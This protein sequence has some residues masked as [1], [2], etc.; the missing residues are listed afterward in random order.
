MVGKIARLHLAVWKRY[1]GVDPTPEGRVHG[2]IVHIRHETLR[3]FFELTGVSPD[4][5]DTEACIIVHVLSPVTT[6]AIGNLVRFLETP[7]GA[8]TCSALNMFLQFQDAGIPW[9]GSVESSLPVSSDDVHGSIR[10]TDQ[11]FRFFQP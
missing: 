1:E 6:T 10:K 5:A 9:S 8:N 3:R 7:T 11:H 2:E 4:I